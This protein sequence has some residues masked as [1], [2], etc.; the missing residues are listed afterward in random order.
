MSKESFQ[1]SRYI[2]FSEYLFVLMPFIVIAIVKAYNSSIATLLQAPDWSFAASILWGQAIVK[3]VSGSSSGPV[4]WQRSSL[5][6][7]LIIVLGL[8][9]SLITLALILISEAPPSFL[10]YQQIILFLLSSVIFFFVGTAGH[11]LM[12]RNSKI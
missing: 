10:I 7:S 9:P 5:V 12:E 1:N 8:I 4:I 6:V 3:L 2:L 11:V